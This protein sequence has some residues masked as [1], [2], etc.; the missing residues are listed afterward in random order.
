MKRLQERAAA[1]EAGAA[2]ASGAEEVA[3]LQ[4]QLQAT[5]AER[6]ELQK[7]LEGIVPELE[8]VLSDRAELQGRVEALQASEGQARA[9]A[10][11]LEQEA[12]ERHPGAE[13]ELAS[14]R[15]QLDGTSAENDGLRQERG[16]LQVRF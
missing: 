2:A 8:G 4:Q 7:E 13:M 16:A 6:A 12:G 15:R 3:A 9:Q 11:A 14:V 5:E 10:K 1:A